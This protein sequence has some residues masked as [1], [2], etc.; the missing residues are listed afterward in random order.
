MSSAGRAPKLLVISSYFHPDRGGGSAVNADL[1]QGLAEKGLDVTVWTSYSH[2]P[3]W[4]DKSGRNGWRI[5]E[6]TLGDCRVQ[7]FGLYIPRHGGSLWER[8]CYE[9]SFMLSL[10]RRLLSIRQYDVVMVF[11]PLVASLAV[12]ACGAAIF[13]RPLWL[14]VQDLAAE[15]AEAG[16]IV[17]FGF[18]A[19]FLKAVQRWLFNRAQIWSTISQVMVKRLSELKAKDQQVLYLPNWLNQ[20]LGD[21]I[22]ALGPAPVRPFPRTLKL[23]YAG[24]FGRKQNLVKLLQALK[25][26]E[27]PFVFT[28]QGAGGDE[29][30][31]RK[32]FADQADHRFRLGP[33]LEEAAF[34]KAIHDAD[35]FV[36]PEIEGG[37]ASFLPSKLTAILASAKPTLC[38][39]D[40]DSPLGVEVRLAGCGATLTW[41]EID[42]LDETLA[43]AA[44]D[45]HLVSKWSESALDHSRVFDRNA[46]IGRFYGTLLELVHLRSG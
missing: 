29:R 17:R 34:A 28:L 35:M 44:T 1:C 42:L 43:Q 7:R 9:L 14:N 6:E 40:P 38:I 30:S 26:C 12:G 36:L 4:R 21:A 45:S 8:L 2:Y 15:A 20:S 27:T 18:L 5:A 13:R 41:D 10:S 25:Q 33:F 46:T 19:R 31:V 16:G 37:G 22:E 24:N 11:C 39:S 3:E 23:L 32:W